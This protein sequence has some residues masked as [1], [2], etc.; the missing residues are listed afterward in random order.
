M[1]TRKSTEGWPKHSGR[2]LG[3]RDDPGSLTVNLILSTLTPVP[4]S[5]T[6]EY[7]KKI[8]GQCSDPSLFVPTSPY[9]TVHIC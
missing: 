9:P 5:R 1:H 7:R 8:S 6:V 2:P 4:T 3:P